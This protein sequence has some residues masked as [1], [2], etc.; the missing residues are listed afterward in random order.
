[1][2]DWDEVETLLD[3]DLEHFEN[4]L[5]MLYGE[6]ERYAEIADVMDGAGR[7]DDAEYFRE[8][9]IDRYDSFSQAI[10][11]KKNPGE[12]YDFQLGCGFLSFGTCVFS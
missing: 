6:I 11:L 7:E 5:G 8:L 1:M 2:A 4:E 9:A 3:S 12:E 10:Q